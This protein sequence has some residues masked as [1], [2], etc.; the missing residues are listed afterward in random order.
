LTTDKTLPNEIVYYKVKNHAL[1]VSSSTFTTSATALSF[2]ASSISE[3]PAA[4]ATYSGIVYFNID[5]DAVLS[6]PFF[7]VD[8]IGKDYA[9]DMDYSFVYKASQRS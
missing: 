2:F 8:M 5:Y 7:Q 4:E 6:L 3:R 9:L 1:Q